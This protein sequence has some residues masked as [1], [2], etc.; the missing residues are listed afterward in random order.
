[1]SKKI[2][3]NNSQ[4]TYTL[5]NSHARIIK[6]LK[7]NSDRVDTDY[8]LFQGSTY[9]DNI[10]KIEELLNV[11]MPNKN[12]FINRLKENY[13]IKTVSFKLD[14]NSFKKYLEVMKEIN[15]TEEFQELKNRYK[16]DSISSFYIPQKLEIEGDLEFYFKRH[17]G[18]APKMNFR[19]KKG[20]NHVNDLYKFVLSNTYSFLTDWV[21]DFKH[22]TFA[23]S[24]SLENAR[25]ALH[26]K[27]IT[28]G[29]VNREHLRKGWDDYRDIMNKIDSFETAVLESVNSASPSLKRIT[30][31]QNYFK[32]QL[33]LESKD[34]EL[35]T[36]SFEG[37][38]V[39]NKKEFMVAS[40]I[41]PWAECKDY[42]EASNYENGLLLCPNH[43]KLFDS[44]MITIDDQGNILSVFKNYLD[45]S[46][47][48][49]DSSRVYLDLMTEARKDFFKYHRDHIFKN[50]TYS[51]SR[52]SKEHK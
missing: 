50:T 7:G 42:E 2:L 37:C 12:I 17:V 25:R 45:I 31:L 43:D 24:T 35:R 47:I 30:S 20:N 49:N 52:L 4:L 10:N 13:I 21:L 32:N 6:Q 8:Y 48:L 26:Q 33:L 44:G 19:F 5:A 46:T 51:K 29:Y 38:E 14:L 1:M 23:L 34:I 22:K 11:K 15:N 28:K 41:K 9:F 3:F 39:S 36:C 18:D 40:H 27:V 16:G